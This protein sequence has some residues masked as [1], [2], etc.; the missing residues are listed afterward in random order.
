MPTRSNQF[1]ND[2]QDTLLAVRVGESIAELR[3]AKG[4][5]QAQLAEMIDLEQEA[6]SRG[7]RGTRVPTLHCLQQL[8]D[9][10]EC[11]VDQLLQRGSTRPNDQLANVASALNAFGQEP[12]TQIAPLA[13]P[14]AIRVD[15]YSSG[16]SSVVMPRSASVKI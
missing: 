4:L 9:A 15:Q 2:A 7:E 5:T 6:V 3:R 11:S 1:T 12:S 10:L 13:R 16:N 8:G 14:D